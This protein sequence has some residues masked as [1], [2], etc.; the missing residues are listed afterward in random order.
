MKA[1]AVV[2]I[3]GFSNGWDVVEPDDPPDLPG[4]VQ[5]RQVALEIQGN[6]RN[7]YHL[8]MTPAGCFT[9]DTWHPTLE[10]AKEAARRLF[11]VP[12]G[13]WA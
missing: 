3:R 9:A 7:G 8:L 1:V 10:D 4:L 11:G 12:P 13:G 6:A 5:E 2:P